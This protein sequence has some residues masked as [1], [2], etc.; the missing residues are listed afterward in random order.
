MTPAMPWV[1]IAGMVMG[2]VFNIPLLVLF[3]VFMF[4]TLTLIEYDRKKSGKE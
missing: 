4:A 1:L 2:L 3:T